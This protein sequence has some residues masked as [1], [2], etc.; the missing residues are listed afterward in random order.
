MMETKIIESTLWC[1]LVNI[2][3]DG[4]CIDRFVDETD[5]FAFLCDSRPGLPVRV[6]IGQHEL[7]GCST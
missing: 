7:G 6:E 2:S 3:P 5:V 1:V 4:R